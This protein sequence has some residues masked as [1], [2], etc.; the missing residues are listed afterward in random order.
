MIKQYVVKWFN[1]SK[2][3]G[4]LTDGK[5]DIFVHHTAILGEG[6]KTLAEG[7]LVTCEVTLKG[8]TYLPET[9]VAVNVVKGDLPRKDRGCDCRTDECGSCNYVTEEDV[10][11]NACG[12]HSELRVSTGTDCCN[13]KGRF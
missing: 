9:L 1:D 12:E 11:C 5:Q 3:Y 6:F 2:G 7:Q 4:F 10:I 8:T 13:A